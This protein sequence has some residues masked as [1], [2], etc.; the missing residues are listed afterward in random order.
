MPLVYQLNNHVIRVVGAKPRHVGCGSE[1]STKRMF[2]GAK[3]LKRKFHA[4][5]APGNKSSREQKLEGARV[6]SMELLFPGAKVSG[7]E[8]SIVLLT[9]YKY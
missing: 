7:N 8:S 2:L 1:S 3:V 9:W 5:F 6:P 4:T